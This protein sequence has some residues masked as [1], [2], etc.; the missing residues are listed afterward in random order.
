MSLPQHALRRRAAVVAVWQTCQLPR[1]ATKPRIAPLAAA[2]LFPLSSRVISHMAPLDCGPTVLPSRRA[3]ERDQGPH[4]EAA[5]VSAV[6]SRPG[7]IASG[8]EIHQK[9]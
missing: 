1:P 6:R 7:R 4:G 5:G 8:Q 3:S 2:T 9:T